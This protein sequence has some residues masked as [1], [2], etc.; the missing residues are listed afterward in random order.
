[1][2]VAE[3]IVVMQGVAAALPQVSK[4]VSDL[5]TALRAAGAVTDEELAAA[6][7]DARKSIEDLRTVIDQDL[8]P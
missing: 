7:A 8:Q 4:A 5:I 1:M 2:G 6:R 3:A